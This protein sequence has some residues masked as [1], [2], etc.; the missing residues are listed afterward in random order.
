MAIG[1]TIRGDLNTQVV[2]A[3]SILDMFIGLRVAPLYGAETKSGEYPKFEI[4][5]A[6][7]LDPHAS[8]RQQGGSYNEVTRQHATDTYNCQDRGLVER[9]D[10]SY[11]ED[12]SR[13]FD[14]E[15]N[16]ARMTLQN[17]LLTHERRVANITFDPTAFNATSAA[18]AYTGTNLA[19]SDPAL[20][21]LEAIEKLEDSGCVPNSI[22]IPSRIM[23]Y[24][25]RSTR[26][27][28]F[29]KQYGLLAPGQAV[30]TPSSLVAA[31]QDR[32]IQQV[33]VGKGA[34]NSAK[35]RS[36]VSLT[37][38]WGQRYIWIGKLPVQAPTLADAEGQTAFGISP[39]DSMGGAMRTFAWNAE[40]GAIV[41]ET[42]RDDDR[43]SEIV[44][45]RQFTDEK[46]I[47][48]RAGQL[49]DTG[50]TGS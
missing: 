44:R 8:D 5:G 21:I 26:F 30:I 15:V 3:Q 45:V 20:D 50:F 33:L 36:S 37:P 27:Q 12:V 14:A 40:G 22:V 41:T 39:F 32:G 28:N 49:I 48:S 34:F 11:R 38:I 42:Y 7:L 23:S 4:G 31:F 6:Q 46:V 9:V 10:D 47:D 24:I 19:T 43:R 1:A 29:A 17:V 2:Q 25:G 16:A 13:F 18:T 35:N